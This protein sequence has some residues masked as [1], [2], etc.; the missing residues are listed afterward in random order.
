[1][2]YRAPGPIREN[3]EQ[4]RLARQNRMREAFET[5]PSETSNLLWKPDEQDEIDERAV[6]TARDFVNQNNFGIAR[7]EMHPESVKRMEAGLEP[8]KDRAGDREWV[9]R[10]ARYNSKKS[11]I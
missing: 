7:L 2:A 3:C 5:G 1:M 6:F 8:E 4:Q 11:Q 10:T 9:A